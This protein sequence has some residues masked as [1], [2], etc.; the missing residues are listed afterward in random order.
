MR[1]TLGNLW[2]TCLLLTVVLL[3]ALLNGCEEQSIP[4]L[5]IKKVIITNFGEVI[6]EARYV[7]ET[8]RYK[9]YFANNTKQ[10]ADV[11]IVDR[12]DPNLGKI[13]PLNSGF[14]DKTNHLV[15]WKIE[16]VPPGGGGFVEFEA[17]IS[18]VTVI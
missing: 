11:G 12:L 5:P 9:I 4:E 13:V 14:Y 15:T 10:K 3:A 18:S 17:V 2:Q 7:G 1:V 16:K 8:I 6:K